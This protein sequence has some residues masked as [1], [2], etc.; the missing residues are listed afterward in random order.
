MFH[1]YVMLFYYT[2]TP[3]F[4]HKKRENHKRE[5]ENFVIM[6]NSFLYVMLLLSNVCVRVFG[7][8][9]WS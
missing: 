8:S 3:S 9:H 1:C 2:F 4:L 7:V 5:H 6:S